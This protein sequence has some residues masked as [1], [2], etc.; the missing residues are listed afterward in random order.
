MRTGTQ[1]AGV[2][3]DPR[4]L[5]G[6]PVPGR[7]SFWGAWS[8]RGAGAGA[9]HTGQVPETPRPGREGMGDGLG[10]GRGCYCSRQGPR[11]CHSVFSKCFILTSV[12]YRLILHPHVR[13]IVVQ[14]KHKKPAPQAEGRKSK[15]RAQ[16]P[17]CCLSFSTP[18]PLSACP[19]RSGTK[20]QPG[21]GRDWTQVTRR[22]SGGVRTF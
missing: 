15:R 3:T 10:L 8:P 11:L 9:G 12:H 17:W 4:E 2:R 18:G 21:T 1:H 13:I 20:P 6:D 7:S 22:F 16:P 5:G 14:L 19:P